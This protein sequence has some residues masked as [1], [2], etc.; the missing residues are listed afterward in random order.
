MPTD[1]Q[2][3]RA[4]ALGCVPTELLIGGRW[5]P[6]STGATM[7]VVNPATEEVLAHV[8]DA[9]PEDGARAVEAARRAQPAWEQTP[10]RTRSE[11][12]YRTFDEVMRRQEQLALLM[13]SE[14]GK[15]RAEA[16]GEVA[17]AAE[18][19]RW[20]AEEAV[21]IDGGFTRRP[22]GTERT[23]VFRQPVG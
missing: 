18:F 6:A 20:F 21:R 8:A 23:L 13:T 1:V 22:D 7:P 4:A 9:T 19:F 11:L 17:Y 14:M 15:P 10:A 2:D 3:A 12:L 5:Q 16:R